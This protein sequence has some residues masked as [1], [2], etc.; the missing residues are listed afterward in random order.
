MLFYSQYNGNVWEYLW[1]VPKNVLVTF[2]AQVL[3]LDTPTEKGSSTKL[4]VTRYI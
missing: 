1:E 3:A 4:T 2:G